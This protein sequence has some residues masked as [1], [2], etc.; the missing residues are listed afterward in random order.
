MTGAIHRVS[1]TG[2]D[3]NTDIEALA[4]LAHKYPFVEWALLYFP[5]REGVARNPSQ[6]WRKRFFDRRMPG[7]SAVHLCGQVAFLELLGDS[8]PTELLQAN[9][10]QL[11]INARVESFTPLEVQSIYRAALQTGK[12]IILQLHPGSEK[13]IRCFLSDLTTE[14][15]ARTHILVDASRGRG[16]QPDAWQHPTDLSPAMWG[17]A[18]GI[19][20]DNVVTVAHQVLALGGTSWLDMESGVRSQNEFDLAKAEATLARTAELLS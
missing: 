15:L 19:S 8:L 12:D 7:A 1:L 6:S 10:L 11:N 4:A 3:D 16:E 5:E 14:E 2:P 18:G 17:Y 9:R 20:P 13:A